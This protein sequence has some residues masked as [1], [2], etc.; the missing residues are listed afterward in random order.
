MRYKPVPPAPASLD[1]V[2]RARDSLPER[3]DPGV[4][5]CARVMDAVDVDRET[6]ADWLVFLAAL[7]LL[8]EC[9]AKY[10]RKESDVE[11]S[12]LADALLANV[13]GAR[14]LDA[15]LESGGLTTPEEAAASVRALRDEA[16][17]AR[18]LDWFCLLGLAERTGGVFGRV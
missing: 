6:A 9:D 7:D 12:A 11:A 1:A 15:L 4:D 10:A 8:Q 14:E 16:R 5:C 13:Y 3:V 17:T 2:A 18:L